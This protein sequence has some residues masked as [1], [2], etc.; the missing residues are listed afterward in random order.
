MEKNSYKYYFTDLGLRNTLLNMSQIEETHIMENLIYN[1]LIFRGY[2]VD[3]GVVKHYCKDVN[4]K[5]QRIT[6][7]IDFVVN[8]GFNKCYIQSCFL[9]N[10]ENRERE[11]KP[12]SMIKNEF[13]K[14]IITKNEITTWYDN[15]GIC[16]MDLK[17]FLLGENIF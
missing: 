17:K 1:E 15:I 7:E 10:D 2:S 16:H 3:V 13:K 12:F 5:T 14:I 11:L 8:N 4:G 9:L 6:N